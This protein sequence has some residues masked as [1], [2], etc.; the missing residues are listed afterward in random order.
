[1]NRWE[2]G[3]HHACPSVR[4]PV[5]SHL[6]CSYISLIS[7]KAN[8]ELRECA[9]RR[10]CLS[11]HT[12]LGTLQRTVQCSES[13]R[14]PVSV[15]VPNP[16]RSRNG[17]LSPPSRPLI[18]RQLPLFPTC[19]SQANSSERPFSGL[20]LVSVDQCAVHIT[21]R[22]LSDWLLLLLLTAM[23]PSSSFFAQVMMVLGH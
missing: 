19:S 14:C 11:W 18:D 2:P 8:D 17:Q 4:L 20:L 9:R 5:H 1:M 22:S 23:A 12:R 7:Q 3:T 16:T 10:F 6:I 13:A 21:N 15:L